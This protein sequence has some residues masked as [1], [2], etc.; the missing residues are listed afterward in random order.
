MKK[1]FHTSQTLCWVNKDGFWR[2]IH[3]RFIG[4]SQPKLSDIWLM[5]ILV[6]ANQCS[7]Y[8]YHLLQSNSSKNLEILYELLK[9]KQCSLIFFVDFV[10]IVKFYH[11]LNMTC[12]CSALKLAFDKLWIYNFFRIKYTQLWLFSFSFRQ[13]SNS[14]ISYNYEIHSLIFFHCLYSL[15]YTQK[16]IFEEIL[17]CRYWEIWRPIW[18][19]WELLNRSNQYMSSE[20]CFW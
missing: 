19:S 14:F 13:T 12:L 9:P 17:T 2:S 20:Q 1:N 5:H 8:S 3:E 11:R 18:S 15:R 4:K 10:H 16:K 6:S 7:Y